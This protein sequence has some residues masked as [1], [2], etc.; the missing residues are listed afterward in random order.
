[1]SEA[2]RRRGEAS[3][4]CL[5]AVLLLAAAASDGRGQDVA[6]E[7]NGILELSQARSGDVESLVR[8]G[9]AAVPA[10]L[11]KLEADGH[12]MVIVQALGRIGDLRATAP[13]LA[14][15]GQARPLER[16]ER[17]HQAERLLILAAL[18]EIGDPSAE[19]TLRAILASG[20]A[21]MATRLAAATALARH[22]SP[23]ARETA[24]VFILETE[25]EARS[26]TYGGLHTSGALRLA[27]IDRALFEAGTTESRRR[28]A[29]RLIESPVAEEKLAII[30]LLSVGPDHEGSKALL[31]LCESPREEPYVRLQ[32]A[33]AA[34]R[35]GAP[36]VRLVAV[37]EDVRGR[38]AP[39]FRDEVN[40]LLSH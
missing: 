14:L 34:M 1:M 3:G 35:S 19:P 25:K 17:E 16:G 22:G 8:L 32:A 9:A 18:R 40:A 10:L 31:A 20:T 29:A 26:G 15:L 33:K 21:D 23:N 27:D 4:R 5:T 28:L 13:L 36:R 39:E 37:L 6:A 38:I 30:A 2:R 24:R 12:P 7:V 11:D